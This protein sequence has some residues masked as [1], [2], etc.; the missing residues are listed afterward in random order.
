MNP[1]FWMEEKGKHKWYAGRSETT[2]W[3]FDK[4]A[5][6][7]L[8]STMKPIALIA[9]PIKNSS[10]T[11]C[12]VLEPFLGS[13]STIITCEQMDRICYAVELEEKFVD[14]SVKRYIEQVGTHSGVFL[15]RDGVKTEYKDVLKEL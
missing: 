3:E 9:Y 4:P 2:V 10:I 8:H 1:A 7:K 12:I 15:I 14:V 13:G 6:S 11:N 5:R